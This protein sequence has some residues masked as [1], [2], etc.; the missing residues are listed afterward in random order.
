[1]K[2]DVAWCHQTY[3][4]FMELLQSILLEMGNGINN[5]NTN[6]IVWFLIIQIY[7]YIGLFYL[8]DL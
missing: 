6:K 3:S 1:M 5:E 8:L 2:K 4:N 7:L